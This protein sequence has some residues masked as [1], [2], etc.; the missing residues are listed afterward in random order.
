MRVNINTLKW[1]ATDITIGS[2]SAFHVHMLA[3]S[4]T[5]SYDDFYFAGEA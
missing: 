2:G 3:S 4:P 1:I 5:A